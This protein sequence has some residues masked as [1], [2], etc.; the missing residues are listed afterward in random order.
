MAR[1]T[2]LVALFLAV[3]LVAAPVARAEGATWD[4]KKATAVAEEIVQA[5]R[6][7]RGALRRQP[8][9][10][11]GQPGRHAFWS[12]REEMQTLVSVS[13]RLHRALAEGAG[14]AETYPTYQRLL[15][16]GRRA[17]E[18]E[19]RIALGEPARGKIDATADAIRR[20]RPFYEDERPL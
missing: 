8:P 1:S 9:P 13:G 11:L 20:I 15:R 14:R 6:A 4:Q 3:T 16:T 12:L 7:L 17:A 19:R 18:E 10:T 2:T 5:A